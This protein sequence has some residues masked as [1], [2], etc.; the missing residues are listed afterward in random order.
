MDHD[1]TD[2]NDD[3]LRDLLRTVAE[4]VVTSLLSEEEL[5][6]LTL[7]RV[8]GYPSEVCVR[9]VAAGEVFE[10]L[11]F[12]PTWHV[13]KPDGEDG[14][15]GPQECAERLASHLQDWIAESGFGWGQQ[16]IA[17]YVLP[18]A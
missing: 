16:R 2:A 5:R 11:M 4:P 9:V 3:A 8:P 15:T 17:R 1:V 13:E 14:L 7:Y 18:P 10:D 12:S 6:S